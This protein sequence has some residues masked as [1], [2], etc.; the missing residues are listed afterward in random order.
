MCSQHYNNDKIINYI[1]YYYVSKLKLFCNRLA[2][3]LCYH[4]NDIDNINNLLKC[5]LLSRNICSNIETNLSWS[6][7]INPMAFSNPKS[8]K[9]HTRTYL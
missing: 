5:P 9:L 6:S 7:K 1:S 8:G 2:N 4:S 3:M